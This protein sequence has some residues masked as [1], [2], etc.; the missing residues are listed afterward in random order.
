MLRGGSGGQPSVRP[1]ARHDPSGFGAT[2][3]ANGSPPPRAG[4][5]YQRT[6]GD[7][8]T[9]ECIGK[10]APLWIDCLDR[11]HFFDPGPALDALL[12]PDGLFRVGVGFE[13]DKVLEPVSRR[14]SAA[15]MPASMLL[16]APS[17]IACQSDIKRAVA[18]IGHQINVELPFH[19][20]ILSQTGCPGK[21]GMTLQDSARPPAQTG[22]PR[23]ARGSGIGGSLPTPEPDL[24]TWLFQHDIRISR[25]SRLCGP[26]IWC[27]VPVN[28][29]IR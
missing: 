29:V 14:E 19:S 16:A 4:V 18:M 11:L 15:A 10:I 7:R 24:S 6:V 22:H 1:D 8:G 27:V 21:P 12:T 9:A 5:R 20:S 28:D 26:L 13:P 3:F 23:L 25:A 2:A 17:Q